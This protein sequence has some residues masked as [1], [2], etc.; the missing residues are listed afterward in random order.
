MQYDDLMKVEN[1]GY[2]RNVQTPAF[3]VAS[4]NSGK[5]DDENKTPSMAI[6]DIQVC[7][8]M[9]THVFGFDMM[10]ILSAHAFRFYGIVC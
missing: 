9:T 7:M 10:N 3:S 8:M 6:D 5:R 2:E 1:P 4:C